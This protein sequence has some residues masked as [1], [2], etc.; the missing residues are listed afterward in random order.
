ML[1]TIHQPEHLP[2][3]GFLDKVRR[4]DLLVLLDTVQYRK[5]YFQNRNRVLTANGPAWV[6]VPVL[7]KGNSDQAIRDVHVTPQGSPR[8]RDK[9]SPTPDH[10]YPTTP[11]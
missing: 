7:T 1:V 8:W 3:L 6:T 2:W 5:N 9:Y 4:A 11:F 10:P